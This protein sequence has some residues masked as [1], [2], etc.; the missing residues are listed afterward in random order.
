MLEQEERRRVFAQDQSLP[1]RASTFHQ[2]A[3][4][5]ADIPLGRFSA[6]SNP[7][8]VGQGASY[9]ACSPA[10]QTQLP[11]EPPLGYRI[12]ELEEPSTVSSSCSPVEQPDGPSAPST[13]SAMS[14]GGPSFS[15]SGDPAGSPVSNPPGRSIPNVAG[16]LPLRRTRL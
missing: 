12:D 13:A 4:A 11:P 2:F 7:Q 3:V 14:S 15:R 9:P 8:I 10:L 5:D 16:S 6:I 1:N